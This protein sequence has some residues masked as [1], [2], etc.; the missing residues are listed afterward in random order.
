MKEVSLSELEIK[1]VD[2]I[3]KRNKSMTYHQLKHILEIQKIL[4]E[5][6]ALY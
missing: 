4:M 6:Q 2:L 1:I 3:K 5:V